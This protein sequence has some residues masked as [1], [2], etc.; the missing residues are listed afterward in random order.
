VSE[1]YCVN[2]YKNSNSI[3]IK[4]K[5]PKKGQAFSFGGRRCTLNESSLRGFGDDVMKKLDAGQTEN[6]VLEWVVGAIE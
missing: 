4:R 5:P 6:N 3:G 2:Y 1:K